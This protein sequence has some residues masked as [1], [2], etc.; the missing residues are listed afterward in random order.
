MTSFWVAF[1][2]MIIG[3]ILLILPTTFLLHWV[4]RLLIWAF[5][6]PWNRIHRELLD[7]QDSTLYMQGASAHDLKQYKLN[8]VTEEFEE[9]GRLARI[10]G[11]E[12]V[13]LKAMRVMRNGKYV[14]RIPAIN[15]SRHYDYPEASM[16]HA[17]MMALD[18]DQ[19]LP[20]LNYVHKQIVPSQRLEGKM[21]P[22]TIEQSE[23]LLRKSITS[24]NDENETVDNRSRI[25]IEGKSTSITEDAG[26]EQSGMPSKVLNH[27]QPNAG[28]KESDTVLDNMDLGPLG[29]LL[30]G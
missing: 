24:P 11:E 21:I 23:I 6:G 4:C 30:K 29:F 5:L 1:L 16:S 7:K 12:A 10:K 3:V 14:S 9:K 27:R 15:Y 19:E 26:I 25:G 13:K 2:S 28:C 18:K 8:A 20:P 22:M 17:T